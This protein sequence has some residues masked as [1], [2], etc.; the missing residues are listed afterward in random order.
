MAAIART[1]R[2]DLR[3]SDDDKNLLEQAADI[4]NISLSNYILSIVLKQA[5]LD[6]KENEKIHLSEAGF[7]NLIDMMDNPPDPTPAL[8]RILK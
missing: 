1:S 5:E 3:I 7:K 6:I 2:I 4:K 8:K